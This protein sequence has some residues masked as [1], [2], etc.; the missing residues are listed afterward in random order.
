MERYA[1]GD[2]RAFGVVYALLAPR[3]QAFLW[4]RTRDEARAEELVHDTFLRMH[5]NRRHFA[6]G[7]DVMPWAFAIARRLLI[8]DHRKLRPP[9]DPDDETRGPWVD[10]VVA[11]HRLGRRMM[12]ELEHLPEQHREAFMLV[13]LE[14]LSMA[15]AAQVLGCTIAAVKVRA[16]RAYETL[17][18]RLGDDVREELGDDPVLATPE[19]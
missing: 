17:R 4:R 1:D 15:E 7:A 6:R 8:D 13:Q 3:L 2:D 5:A 11:I 18:D 9:P 12:Q 14:G 16:Y 10:T 19:R